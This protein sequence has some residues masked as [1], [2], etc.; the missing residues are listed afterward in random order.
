VIDRTEM[1]NNAR[2]MEARVRKIGGA[3]GERVQSV[4]AATAAGNGALASRGCYCAHHSYGRGRANKCWSMHMKR[5]SKL[6]ASG[7]SG[8]ERR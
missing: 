3:I 5:R 6:V 1:L 7:H 8:G 4:T 2:S